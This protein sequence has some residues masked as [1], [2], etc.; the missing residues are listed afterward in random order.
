MRRDNGVE[1]G[2]RERR[3]DSRTRRLK[4]GRSGGQII[5]IA[6]VSTRRLRHFEQL[7][8]VEYELFGTM[9]QV[10]RDQ[11]GQRTHVG[12]RQ[13]GKVLCDLHLELEEQRCEL[14]AEVG[15]VV[16]R[17]CVNEGRA[18]RDHRIQGLLRK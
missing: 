12:M 9:S 1:I 15:E 6:Q 8:A 17:V 7:L 2:P 14:V 10:E 11:V 13:P 18:Q 16:S 3:I 5:G 4:G